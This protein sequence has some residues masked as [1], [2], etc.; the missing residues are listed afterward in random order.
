MALVIAV[1]CIGIATYTLRLSMIGLAGR[2]S[3]PSR[4][5]RA[6]RFV[7]VAALTALVAPDLFGGASGMSLLTHNPRL[8]AGAVAVVV[9]WRTRNVLLTVVVGMTALWLFLWLL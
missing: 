5:E 8:W 9:A 1:V 2:V 7:P 6:L 3:L 4:A